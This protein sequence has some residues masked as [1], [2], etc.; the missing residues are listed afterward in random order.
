MDE[1]KVGALNYLF[2]NGLITIKQADMLAGQL[3][4]W[5]GMTEAGNPSTYFRYNHESALIALV[6]DQEVRKIPL[7]KV[8]SYIEGITDFHAI[9][10]A[11]GLTR[12]EAM[13]GRAYDDFMP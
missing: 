13:T 3:V 8:V 12:E 2:T 6:Q 10:I 11:N 4:N 5:H 1:H 7:D 9:R